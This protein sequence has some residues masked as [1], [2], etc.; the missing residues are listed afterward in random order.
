MRSI[1]LS[2]ILGQDTFWYKASGMAQGDPDLGYFDGTL[3]VYNLMRGYMPT[4]DIS[5]LIPFYH[6]SGNNRGSLTKFPVNG[7]PVTGTGDI[8]GEGNNFSPGD[9]RFFVSS[10]PFNMVPGDTQDIVLAIVGALGPHGGSNVSSVAQLQKS[11]P[12]LHEFWQGLNDFDSP[13]GP[14]PK[15]ESYYSPDYPL[16]ILAQNYP[17][18]FNKETMIRFRLLGEMNIRLSIYNQNGQLIKHLFHGYLV[19]NEYVCSWDGRDNN[20]KLVPSGI[21]IIRMQSDAKV[22]SKKMILIK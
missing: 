3:Q 15:S 17:N 12:L 10:G 1:N 21:Y 13:K 14:V 6:G 9:R 11:A 5:N 4:T 18:P 2:T 20:G 16:F 8:D 22:Q 19:K 7:D